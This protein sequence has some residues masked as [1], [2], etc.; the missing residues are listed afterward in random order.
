MLKPG[1]IVIFIAIL[2][3]AAALYSSQWTSYHDFTGRCLECHIK[4][5]KP[6]ET[7]RAFSKDLTQMCT[8]CHASELEL[9]H[10]VDLNPSMQVPANLPLDWK[11]AVTC[12]T[13]HPVHNEG[14]GPFRLRSRL[15]GQGFCMLCHSDIESELHKVSLGA[16][17]AAGSS[18]MKYV[19][20]ELGGTLDEL[21]L[22]CLA[23]HDALTGRDAFVERRFSDG[24]FF[25]NRG[26][27]GLSH[28]IGVS[29][30][31]ARRKYHGAYKPVNELPREIKLFGGNVGC[32]SCHNPYSKRHFSLVMSNEGSALCLA[33][34]VK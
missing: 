20:L 33:C 9:S 32:G 34:H 4:E 8:G 3:G 22:K 31:E 16:A 24:A 23:C 13:C 28:P 25:H 7:P 17:H 2:A 10:P 18:S 15:S 27:I 12:V 21:S 1:L 29:Y 19:E 26:V 5:P 14:H 30:I 6:G 11:G